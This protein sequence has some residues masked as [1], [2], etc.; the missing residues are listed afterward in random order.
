MCNPVCAF[1]HLTS[2]NGV[3]CKPQ[4]QEVY[5]LVNYVEIEATSPWVQLPEEGAHCTESYNWHRRDVSEVSCHGINSPVAK[6]KSSCWKNAEILAFKGWDVLLCF[7]VFELFIFNF[8]QVWEL[9][10][11]SP[12]QLKPDTKFVC[13]RPGT[14][15]LTLPVMRVHILQVF[16]VQESVICPFSSG[17]SGWGMFCPI[18]SDCKTFLGNSG[19]ALDREIY[20][21]A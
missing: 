9:E 8:L 15:R 12:V 19:S 1:A 11:H 17:S 3:R 13:L 10:T 21:Q 2:R 16:Q 7:F 18:C 14:I 5:I 20:G 6:N 4:P